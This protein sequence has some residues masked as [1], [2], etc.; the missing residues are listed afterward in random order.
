MYES[1]ETGQS[2]R[3]DPLNL[4]NKTTIMS[5]G[6]ELKENS[7]S[8]RNEITGLKTIKI[9]NLKKIILIY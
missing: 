9:L 6:S 4:S 1:D 2:E 8:M 7:V 3:I 5:D